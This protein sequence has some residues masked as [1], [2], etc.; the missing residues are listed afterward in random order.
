MA[1]LEIRQRQATREP[2]LPAELVEGIR[3]VRH[4]STLGTGQGGAL[5]RREDG[6]IAGC[7][8]GTETRQRQAGGTAQERVDPAEV[9]AAIFTAWFLLS[10]G[11]KGRAG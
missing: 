5:P 2:R 1:R 10:A 11:L 7:E 6:R 8:A 4:A 9:A 3:L